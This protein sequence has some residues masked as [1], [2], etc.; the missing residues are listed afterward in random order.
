MTT[1]ITDVTK[2]DLVTPADPFDFGAGRVDLNNAGDAPIVF[3]E[4]AMQ[5]LALGSNPVTALD[6]NLPSINAPTMPGTVT[7]V[8]TTTNVSGQDYNFDVTTEAPAGATIKVSPK[9]GRIRAGESRTFE[10]TITSNAPSAQ[11]FGKIT[12]VSRNSSQPDV[13]LPVAFFNDQGDITLSQSCNPT[14][15]PQ[16]SS[17]TC[18]VT[19]FNDSFDDATV[20]LQSAVSSGL[21]ITGAT[22]ATVSPNGKTASVVNELLEG[23]RDATP[24][25]AAGN[26]PAGGYLDLELFGSAPVPVGDESIVN[27]NVPAYLFGGVTYTRIGITSNGY[28][29][30]GG[31]VAADVDFIPQDLPDPTRPNGVLAPYWTDLDGTGTEG[32]RATILTDGVDEWIVLQWD[33]RLW[34]STSPRAMQIWIGINGVEDISYGY[35]ASSLGI[36]TPPGYGLTVG[37]ENPSGTGGAQIVGPPTSSYQIT[38]T[39]GAPGETLT[40]TLTILGVDKGNRSLTTSMTATTVAGTTTVSTGI[41]VTKK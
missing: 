17:T 8:R 1:A 15:I 16:S 19:A 2:E 3:D 36:N 13:H 41:V 34:G 30:V 31:G 12:I 39:P 24:A 6:V 10:V 32:V 38:T 21:K 29:V 18:T 33:V 5:M 22:G 27:F 35:A 37:A 20:N 7:V 40:Y 11:Y 25:I 28:V 23:E 9:Q 14:S 4:S 26:T